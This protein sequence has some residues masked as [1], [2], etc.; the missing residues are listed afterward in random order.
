[1]KIGKIIF[2]LMIL[3]STTVIQAQDTV[4]VVVKSNVQKNVIQLRWAATSS[5]AWFY[6]NNNGVIVERYTVVRNGE[7]LD[8]PE[9]T[10]LTPTPLKPRE[11]NDW[12]QIAVED[13]YA[14]I[15]AQ[16]LYGESFEVSGGKKG[17]AEII[18]L[19][20]EQEQ[21]YAM[22][23]YAA[24]L[25][26]KAALFAGWGFE[27][28]SVVA[29]ERYLYRVTPVDNGTRKHIEMG[30]VYTSLDDYSE[31]PKPVEL[32][33]IFGNA[34][35]ML[36]WNFALLENYYNTYF[37]ERSE[38]GKT[39]QRLNKTPISNITGGERMFR[40]DSISNN[41]TYHYRVIGLTAFGDESPYSDTVHGQGKDIL[42]YVPHIISA[43][44]DDNW[45]FDVLWDFDE[46]GNELL[47]A[48]ELQRSD[49]D[50]GDFVPIISDIEPAK[51][52]ISYKNP[53]PEN[54]LRIVAI[55]KDGEP[56]YSFPF[57]LQIPDSIPP[58]IP[59]GLEGYVDTFGVVQLKWNANTDN[60]ILGYRIFRAQTAGEELV[61]LTDIAVLDTVFVDSV[62]VRN[63]NPKVY[64]AVSALD[65]RYNQSK[66]CAV[67]EITKPVLIK[68]TPPYI[69]KFEAT[70]TGINLEW[71]TGEDESLTSY[72]I[73]R[74][75][76]QADSVLIEINNAETKTY[77]DT[78]VI[79]ETL[80]RYAI[81]A[82]NSGNLQS[83]PSPEITVRAKHIGQD[84]A[85]IRRFTG[86]RTEKGIV[87][88]WQHNIANIRSVSIYKKAQNEQFTAWQELNSSIREAIDT[89][90]NANM[91]YEYLLI[92]KDQNGKPQNAQVKIK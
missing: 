58:E 5:S 31:L 65:K 59:K 26:Y 72:I 86:K 4:A 89:Q 44:P 52:N 61:P 47:Q 77:T 27:D 16:A 67:V 36:T 11:L 38:D 80:Y 23:L 34:S 1:M 88:Q 10:V 20:Q 2:V 76:N 3:V 49:T 7:V 42:I 33:A 92:I 70:E 54:Y 91:Q 24:D 50:K 43:I 41:K 56:T 53:E 25:S 21:R 18:A 73:Y 57:L 68:P 19:S 22:S 75:K 30:S 66:M 13:D 32:D 79:G 39:F 63:L 78:S 60:D 84:G 29:G 8:Q 40:I 69:S 55:P 48:F 90:V 87:L 62:N 15:I 14:A 9:K 6:T 74:G 51:R 81:V 71:L 37:V 82:K 45:V 46:R 35:V 28:K 17:I 12:Q 85:K 83:D 64:Y